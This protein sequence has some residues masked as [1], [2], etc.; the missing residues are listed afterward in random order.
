MNEC[1]RLNFVGYIKHTYI[2]LVYKCLVR[3]RN[4][5]IKKSVASRH[6]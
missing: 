5:N 4:T 6:A 1:N 3:P 2:S